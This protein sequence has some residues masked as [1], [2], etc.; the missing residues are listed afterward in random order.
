MGCRERSLVERHSSGG[1]KPT[2]H[3]VGWGVTARLNCARPRRTP[4]VAAAREYG[5]PTSACSIPSRFLAVSPVRR[6]SATRNAGVTRDRSRTSVVAE[7][8]RTGASD[9]ME[10]TS[11]LRFARVSATSLRDRVKVR[12]SVPSLT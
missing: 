10:S 1:R 11:L 5:N 12:I 4:L 3:A 6:E 7:V 9:R 2:W 8:K